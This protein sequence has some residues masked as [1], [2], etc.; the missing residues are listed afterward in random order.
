MVSSIP[1]LGETLLGKGW[2]FASERSL[3]RQGA[4]LALLELN[5]QE[6][7]DVLKKAAKSLFPSVRSVYQKALK[8]HQ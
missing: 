3:W 4:A 5:T 2:D 6:A 7:R 1:F 8:D